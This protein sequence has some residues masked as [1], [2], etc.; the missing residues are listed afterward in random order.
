M[1]RSAGEGP[2][3]PACGVLAGEGAKRSRAD[4]GGR[5]GRHVLAIG[6]LGIEAVEPTSSVT[7]RATPSP[8][9]G[10][11]SELGVDDFLAFLQ[12][13]GRIERLLLAV[14]GGPDSIAL[15]GLAAAAANTGPPLCVATVDHGLRPESRHEA[16]DVAAMAATF[17]L[18]HAVLE[19]H[20]PPPSSGIQEAARNARYDLLV[21]HA[22]AIGA[23][24]LA[25]AHTLDDQ[26]ETIL[27]RLARGSGPA[28]LIGMRPSTCRDGIVHLRPLLAVPKARLIATCRANGWAYHE[29]PSNTDPRYAR[30][31]WRR[32]L[33][34][35][36]AEGLDADRFAVLSHRL[37][38]AEAALDLQADKA[39]SG[40]L[41]ERLDTQVVL[42]GR[43]LAAEAE[44]TFLRVLAL[45]IGDI[46]VGAQPRLPRLQRLERLGH[47]LR[48]AIASATPL[49]RTLA[50]AMV[51]ARSD[52]TIRVS[53][54][55]PRRSATSAD[56]AQIEA[57]G[58]AAG[59]DH[60]TN[61][62]E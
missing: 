50:G 34:L 43:A 3:L 54:E 57:R 32:I 52:A 49:K 48:L 59:V 51:W 7:L 60:E 28:G 33:P 6:S 14:S 31:R 37:R 38:R 9:S 5:G 58:K 16:G 17:G 11:R 10:R 21:A 39:Y 8:A 19:W 26:A 30:S 25:T 55:P 20:D 29:D 22:R 4:Q 53:R 18:P 35:L 23:S 46:G 24:H 61:C 13:F 45:A 15:M 12:P 42:D 2:L 1:L 41:V 44:E 62:V 27:Y 40:T 47:D 36:E 56:R